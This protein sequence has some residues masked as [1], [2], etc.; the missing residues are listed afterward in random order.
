MHVKKVLL[1][2]LLLCLLSA[3]LSPAALA[4]VEPPALGDFIDLYG[5]LLN[6]GLGLLTDWL[7][8]QADRLAPEF[9]R[10]LKDLD[11]D[12]LLSDLTELAGKTSGMDD[13]ALR[14]AVLALA[15]KH[16]VH[17]VDS[18]V[19]QLM[20]LCRTLEKLDASQL[21]ERMDALQ[22]EVRPGGMRGAWQSVAGAV[23][24][25]FDWISRTLG[26]LFR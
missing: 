4:A 24:D 23:T 16:G 18:Q 20:K 8:G 21:R 1:F 19:Q 7:D 13:E 5:A 14:E 9:R 15:E 25:A 22:Q 17:L 3:V 6:D 12:A 26:G 10:T 2:A 11:A